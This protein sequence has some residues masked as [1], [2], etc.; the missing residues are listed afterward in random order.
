MKFGKLLRARALQTAPWAGNYVD[1]KALKG[2]IKDCLH[3][4]KAAHLLNKRKTSHHLLISVSPAMRAFFDA[5]DAQA[6]KVDRLYLTQL[7]RYRD[8]LDMLEVRTTHST[9]SVLP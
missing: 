2:L 7:R 3:D 1:Y 5:V 6:S 8:A 4:A 9:A